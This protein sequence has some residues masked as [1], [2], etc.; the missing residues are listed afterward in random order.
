VHVVEGL[1]DLIQR[2]AVGDK[3][4]DFELAIHVVLDKTRQLGTALDT[5]ERAATPTPLYTMQG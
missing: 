5:S 2:L 4:V 1:V 3:L